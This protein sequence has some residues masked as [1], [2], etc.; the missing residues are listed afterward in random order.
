[1]KTLRTSG[2]GARAR[3]LRGEMLVML[4]GAVLAGCGGGGDGGSNP[5]PNSSNPP[6]PPPPP[7]PAGSTV[8]PLSTDVIDISDN[9]QIGEDHWEDGATSTGGLGQEVEGLACLPTMPDEYHVHTH[10]SIF[11]NGEAL[12]IPGNVGIHDQGAGL[13]NCFYQI[14]THDSS[15]KLHIEA[16]EAGTFTLGQFFAIWGQSLTDTDVA[17]L[18]GM[19]VVVYVTDDGE[20]TE[21]TENWGDIE[22]TSHRLIT[23]QVGTA[24]DE[25]PNITWNGD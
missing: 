9:R 12:A 1:M 23:I 13:P 15:G 3:G 20:V 4:L 16:E 11:L 6:P 25:I 14:H 24:I 8:P 5:P 10:L 17:G 19:P 18:T 21:V 22:L 7:P 2:H